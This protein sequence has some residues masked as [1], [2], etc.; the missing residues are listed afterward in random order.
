[1]SAPAEGVYGAPHPDLA[2]VPRDARRFSPLVPGAEGLEAAAE[3]SLARWVIAAPP[4]VL[5]RRYVLAQALRTLVPGGALIAMAPKDRGGARLRGELGAFGCAV[6]ESAGRHQ[7]IC[8]TTRPP[9]PIGLEA[10]IVQG[11]PQIVPSLGLWSQPGVFSWD[12]VDPGSA[13]LLE[14]AGDFSGRGADLGC[15]IG[16]LSGAVLASPNVTALTAVD[17]D[18]RAVL[19]A[20]HNLDDPRVR[21]MQH[22]LRGPPP[23]LEGLDFVIMNPPFHDGGSEDRRLGQAFIA[24]AAALLRRGGVCRLVANIG[25]PYEA[26]LAEHFAA[27]KPL[28]VKGGYKLFEA[29]R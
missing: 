13:Q 5:E 15:G 18:R 1:M 16:V 25:M 27:V 6:V 29:R 23:G 14:I 20:E 26:P 28:G 17:I 4:A 22:D 2:E 21:V 9:S 8:V 7:R 11:G 3:A 10:A 19:A 12:R 24:R